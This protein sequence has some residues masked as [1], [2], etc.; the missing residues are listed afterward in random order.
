[1]KNLT[2]IVATL[3]LGALV[4]LVG[5]KSDDSADDDGGGEDATSQPTDGGDGNSCSGDGGSC[6]GDGG[7][8]GG[9]G[10]SCG[11]K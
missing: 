10:G 8:C 11:G 4:A 6:S 3:S 7:S 5:C 1:M 2:R 9:E